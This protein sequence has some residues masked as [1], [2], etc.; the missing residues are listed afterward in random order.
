MAGPAATDQ[1]TV[2]SRD[3]HRFA[4]ISHRHDQAQ[5]IHAITGV[6]AV[7]TAQGTWVVPPS[8]AV[9]VPAG[10]EH[11]TRSHAAVRFRALLIDAAEA[12]GLPGACAV[13]EVTPL[14]RE[15]I[16]RLA[17]LAGAPREPDFCQAV[18]RLLLLELSFLP[19]EPLNLPTP[20]HA[21]L[22]RFCERLRNEPALAVSLETAAADLHM[23]RSSFMRRFQRETGMS[24][25]RWRQQARL[26]HALSLLAD[27]QSI[28][29]V[30]LACGYESP[31]AFSAMF[32]R[33]LGRSPTDYFASPA[34]A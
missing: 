26:L 8:R 2:V 11:E 7:T 28:L 1:I 23:S 3:A 25:A 9:W 5:L 10:I 29:S 33:S 34:G 19:V 21:Q 32:R 4:S 20:R 17:A 24:L 6:V 30:A 16:L 18:T 22:A 27:G 12:Q 31:S 13:V 15:L 14:L